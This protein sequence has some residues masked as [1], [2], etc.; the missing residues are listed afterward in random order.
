MFNELAT[1]QYSLLAATIET[2]VNQL[3][4]DLVLIHWLWLQARSWNP[5][6]ELFRTSG[7]KHAGSYYLTVGD[8]K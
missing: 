7:Y 5:S 4:G 1:E 6:I 3:R 2:I 8:R